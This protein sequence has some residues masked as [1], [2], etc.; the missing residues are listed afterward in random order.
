MDD[1]KSKLIVVMENRLSNCMKKISFC[2]SWIKRNYP[3]NEDF[4]KLCMEIVE[5]KGLSELL[6]L[7][8]VKTLNTF[9]NWNSNSNSKSK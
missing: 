9:M 2:I 7:E 1:Q 3:S 8:S 6:D 4:I 5:E